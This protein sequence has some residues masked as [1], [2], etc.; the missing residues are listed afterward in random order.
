MVIVPPLNYASVF[1]IGGVLERMTAEV[2]G[3]RDDDAVGAVHAFAP[4][5]AAKPKRKVMWYSTRKAPA[6][7]SGKR[8]RQPSENACTSVH[9]ISTNIMMLLNLLH[10]VARHEALT[11]CCKGRRSVKP[12][13]NLQATQL[14]CSPAL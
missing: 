7:V 14:K 3:E 13:P 5:L 8:V 9:F 12:Y 6:V 11:L 10:K 4:A 1:R 2:R